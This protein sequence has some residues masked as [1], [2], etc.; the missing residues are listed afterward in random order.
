MSQ[1][2]P[3]PSP[4]PSHDEMRLAAPNNGVITA[5]LLGYGG[6]CPF[7]F[8]AAATMLELRTPFA[9]PAPLL[10]GYGAV[11]LSFVGALHWGAQ[12]S[13]NQARA[14][15]FIWSV[16]PA[17]LGW[18]SLFLPAMAAA[19]CLIIGL[20]ICWSYDMRLIKRGEWPLFMRGLRTVLTL[21]ACLSLSVVFI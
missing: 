15:R 14:S 12:L 2:S 13:A 1:T 7:V 20:I 10:I 4:S 8:L 18:I 3:L 16:V 19:T 6:L 21:I 9:P 17:L 11:I 5:R